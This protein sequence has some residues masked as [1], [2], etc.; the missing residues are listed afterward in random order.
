MSDCGYFDDAPPDHVNADGVKWWVHWSL[1]GH[2][3]SET[4]GIGKPL[5]GAKVFIAQRP[6]GFREYVLTR[7]GKYIAADSALEGIG[8]Q[9]DMARLAEAI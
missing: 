5:T 6:D 8:A 9:I 1:T 7:N 3:T 4:L 2:A